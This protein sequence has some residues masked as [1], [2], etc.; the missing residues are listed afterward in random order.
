MNAATFKINPNDY[1]VD[2]VCPI[3]ITEFEKDQ[4]II[5]LPC[6]KGHI[7]HEDCIGEWI[8]R[9]NTCPLCKAPITADSIQNPEFENIPFISR[10]L[11]GAGQPLN[12]LVD[13]DAEDGI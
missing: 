5:N 9:D 10:D 2:D 8:R 7:F 1:S 4:N 13:N 3:C 6:N 12:R 11:E